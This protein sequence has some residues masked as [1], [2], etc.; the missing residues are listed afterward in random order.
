MRGLVRVDA[1]NVDLANGKERPYDALFCLGCGR[2][3]FYVWVEG[4][5]V[6]LVCTTCVEE[7]P[8]DSLKALRTL[9]RVSRPPRRS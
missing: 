8:V 4:G 6:R 2:N 5:L 1:V 3:E 7:Y 9:E